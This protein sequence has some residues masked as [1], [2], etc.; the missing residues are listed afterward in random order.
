VKPTPPNSCNVLLLGADRRKLWRFSTSGGKASAAGEHHTAPD[1]PLPARWVNKGWQE[2]FN[3]RLNIAWLPQDQVFLRVVQ[4]PKC[5][6]AELPQM[7]EFQ[8]EKLSPLPVTHIEWSFEPVPYHGKVPTEMQ[9]VVVCIAARDAVQ[10]FLGRLEG[11]GFRPD[12]LEAP[13][14]H[15]VLATKP[16]AD[17]AWVYPF[18]DG[19]RTGCLVAW[20]YGGAL[21]NLSLANLTEA[22]QWPRE[23][24][25]HLEATVWAGE[26]EGW[27]TSPPRWHLVGDKD[28]APAWERILSD[29]GAATVTVQEP[30]ADAALAAASARRAANAESLANLLPPDIASRYRSQWQDRVMARGLIAV[31]CLYVLGV[32]S[33]LVA[34]NLLQFQKTELDTQVASLSQ[35]YTNALVTKGRI[36]VMKEQISLKYAA[37][38]G[39]KAAAAR[40]P[41][42][43]TL[44]DFSFSQGSRFT[45]RGVAPAAEVTKITDFVVALR[46]VEVNGQPLFSSVNQGN[47]GSAPGAAMMSWNATCELRPAEIK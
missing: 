35:T 18:T 32:V 14:L 7:I 22:D 17:G 25:S 39:L 45:L 6:P 1:E 44:T 29:G 38:E 26:L 37:L 21:Q 9:T 47:I 33:Y 10:Q 2:F 5:E 20:W 30:L 36:T 27:L 13:M 4:L 31:F 24:S 12:R 34:L 40:L 3:P 11:V 16:D 42:G 19:G 28:S 43:L 41:E 46:A 23:L 15:Q 8:L